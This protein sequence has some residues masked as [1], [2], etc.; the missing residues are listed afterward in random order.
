M[1]EF[2]MMTQGTSWRIAYSLLLAG[3][4]V[5]GLLTWFAVR[6]TG[7]VGKGDPWKL[8]HGKDRKRRS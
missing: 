8:R 3:L 5:V 1:S 4:V 6:N 2:S 7:K